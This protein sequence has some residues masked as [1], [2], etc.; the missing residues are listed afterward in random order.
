ML[1]GE[2]VVKVAGEKYLPRLQS[3][4]DDEYKSYKARAA[5][6]N[7]SARTAEGFVRLVCRRP[8][9]IKVPG[10]S[11]AIG[12]RLGAFV[13]DSDTLGTTLSS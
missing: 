10:P 11:S 3:Q 13:N 8:P 12:R 2:D 5:F 6:F 9:F 7:G 4:T 1:A